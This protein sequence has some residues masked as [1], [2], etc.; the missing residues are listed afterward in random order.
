V[1]FQPGKRKDWGKYFLSAWRVN[2]T[3]DIRG[4]VYLDYREKLGVAEGF[5]LNYDLPELGKGDYKYYY[6][7]ERSRW[8]EEGQPAEFQRYLIRW[9]HY[10][11]LTAQTTLSAEYWKI[12]D[13][14]RQ[15][16]GDFLKDYFF[17][18]YEKDTQPLSYIL[19]NHAFSAANLNI[20]LQ[21]RTNRSYT[22]KEKLPE[23]SFSL[24]AYKLG[25]SPR[26]LK[27]STTFSSLTS[28]NAAPSDQDDDVVRF[29][30]F[31]EVSLPTKVSLFWFKPFVGI[32]ETQYSKDKNGDLLG[33]RTTFY[34]GVSISTKFYRIFDT[35]PGFL[36]LDIDDI[37]HIV[38]PSIEY[39]Y[40]HQPTVPS[41]KLQQFDEIDSLS[42]NNSMDLEL[43]NKLQT[44]RKNKTVDFAVFKFNTS[45]RFKPEGTASSFSDMGLDLELLPFAW[46]RMEADAAYDHF[47]DYFKTVNVDA[48]FNFSDEHSFGIGHRYERKAGKELTSE[49]IWRLNPKWKFRV[50]ERYQFSRSPSFKRGFRE[51]E[52][53][54]SRDLHCWQLD[55]TYNVERDKG[56]TIWFILRLKAFPEIGFEFDQSYHRPKPR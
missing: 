24:P 9:R 19:L 18:E 51:Q 13:S 4:R 31:N 50:Y 37:R 14:K 7:Q 28:K 48:V 27:N 30:T 12:E 22:Q 39:S 53:A 32:R 8:I 11:T 6:T 56:E 34:S 25:I 47:N 36:G 2:V 45:Y 23:I 15:I 46:L 20:L 44:K 5:G 52:Y 42:K 49:L 40:R 26:Y 33:P 35:P 21:K 17:R 54:V 55:V 10:Q 43:V 29:D 1:R 3:D 41:S 16:G 38:T